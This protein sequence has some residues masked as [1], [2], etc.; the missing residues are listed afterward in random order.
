MLLFG[1]VF[2]L[3]RKSDGAFKSLVIL[4]TI[5]VAMLFLLA[6][7]CAAPLETGGSNNE[8]EY[9]YKED[10]NMEDLRE[11]LTDLQ[12]AVTQE[13]A[14]EPPF[15]NEYWDNKEEGIYVDVVSGEPL[16]SSIDKFDS[17][18]GWPSF[19]RPLHESSVVENEDHSF[20][21]KRVEVRS[22]KAGSHLG[23]LFN[24]GPRP[25]GLRYCINSASLRF[26]PKERLEE[27]G[28]G[29]YLLLFD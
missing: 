11:R 6:G 19:T 18:S 2:R 23:H 10:L 21:M 17:G 29:Q 7:G 25:T 13:D 26:I 22:N 16:F 15:E 3:F 28:Y 9:Q 1:R 14:T 8:Q 24:D 5:G 20:G 4:K 27:E 12:F